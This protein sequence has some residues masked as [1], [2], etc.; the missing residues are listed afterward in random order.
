MKNQDENIIKALGIETLPDDQKARILDQS[1][2]LIQQ[3]LFLRLM[4][5]LPD[6][7]RDKF[8]EILAPT[9]QAGLNEFILAEAPHFTDWIVEEI[10]TLKDELGGLGQID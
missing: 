7:K 2:E 1:N 5:A 3:R 9:D 4:E 8:N 10:A 6:A